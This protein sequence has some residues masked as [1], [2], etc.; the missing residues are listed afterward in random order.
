VSNVDGYE[1]P[2]DLYYF[3][4]THTWVRP[5]GADRARIGITAFATVQAGKVS[6]IRVRPA[7]FPLAQG[8][9]FGTMETFKWVG[10][11]KSPVGGKIAEVNPE[12]LK[13]FNVVARSPYDEGWMIVAS[14][15]PDLE[16][17]LNK[18]L[19]GPEAVKWQEEEVAKAKATSIT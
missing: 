4:E 19:N 12:L 9:V 13:D 8:K 7:G 16:G 1:V 2:D 18:L 15:I 17:D 5:E 3:A 14:E 10:A 6:N 11:L